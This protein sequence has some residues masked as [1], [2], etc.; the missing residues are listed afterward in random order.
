MPMTDQA[1]PQACLFADDGETPNN[2]VLPLLVHEPVKAP[3]TPQP[4]PT[5]VAEPEVIDIVAIARG[6][7]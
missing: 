1:P 5:P 6:T 4:P 7:N 2:P 3:P